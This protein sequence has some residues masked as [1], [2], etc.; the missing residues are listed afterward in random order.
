VVRLRLASHGLSSMNRSG[1]ELSTPVDVVERM[2]AVQS[3]DFPAGKW[4]L[5]ARSPSS[6]AQDVVATIDSGRIVR[7]WPMRGTLHLVP[8]ADLNWML[9]LTTAR[10]VAAFAT[11]RKQLGLDDATIETAREI[12][13]A[14]LEGGRRLSRAEFL[15]VLEQNEISTTGQ[16]GYHLIWNLAQTG[17]LCWGPHEGKQQALVLLSEWIPGPRR[18][19]RAEALGEFLLRYLSGHGP[20]TLKDF[21][22]WSGLTVA[23]AKIGL[24]QVQDRLTELDVDGVVHYLC[25]TSDTGES[26]SPVH[27]RAPLLLLPAFDEYLLGYQDRSFAIEPENLL[28]VV[29]GKNGIFFPIMVEAG[30]VVGTWRPSSKGSVLTAQAQPLGHLDTRQEARFQRS[31]TEYSRFMGKPVRV[32]AQAPGV[33]ALA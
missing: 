29:P 20:A 10:L 15:Q 4:A 33:A 19:E 14:A 8:A 27:Q 24:G 28:R 6:T 17:T 7:S 25:S 18:L 21:A 11:R 31:V 13:I 30:R 9:E 32:E 26:G 5:G 1:T 23:D 16:R 3:Q 2:L 22:W 12:A